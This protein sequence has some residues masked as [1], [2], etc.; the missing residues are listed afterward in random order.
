ML[1]VSD[2]T[3]K[4]RVNANSTHTL[5]QVSQ[6]CADDLIVSDFSTRHQYT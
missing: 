5:S 3:R 4:I 2:W 6:K 1:R